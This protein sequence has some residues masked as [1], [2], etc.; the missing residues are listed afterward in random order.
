M[1]DDGLSF[2]LSAEIL[3][4]L[5]T[6]FARYPG[7]ERV[8]VFGS[9]AKGTYRNASDIDLAVLAPGMDDETFAQLW[10]DLDDLPLVFTLD[11]LHWD[12]LP[13]GRIR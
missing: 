7:I 5:R 13:A 10:N 2:G 3:E 9:R 12:R 11:V 4:W 6:V 8:L 1:A